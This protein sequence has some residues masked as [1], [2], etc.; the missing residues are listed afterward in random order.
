MLQRLLNFFKIA[1]YVLVEFVGSLLEFR[2]LMKV[3]DRLVG[4]VTDGLDFFLERGF[5]QVVDKHFLV[6]KRLNYFIV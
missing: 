3:L 1:M 5:V 4:L 2:L 6:S